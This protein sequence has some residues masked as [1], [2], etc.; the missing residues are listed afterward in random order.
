MTFPQYY[1][2]V[3]E[4]AARYVTQP[5]RNRRRAP[6]TI[7]TGITP[8]PYDAAATKR[9]RTAASMS[10]TATCRPPFLVRSTVHRRPVHRPARGRTTTGDRRLLPSLCRPRD[11][12]STR[13]GDGLCARLHDH[14]QSGVGRR[15][16]RPTGRKSA[17]C[18]SPRRT[19][20]SAPTGCHRYKSPDR[21]AAP[22]RKSARPA[23]SSH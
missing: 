13:P 2:T 9:A 21:R 6:E 22:K 3:E 16:L 8:C 4:F 15:P 20:R 7:E 17:P 19:R 1:R 18:Q 14:R 23:P 11:H 10:C 5:V 12:R